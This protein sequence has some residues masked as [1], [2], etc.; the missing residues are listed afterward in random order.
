MCIRDSP[1]VALAVGLRSAGHQPVLVAEQH[2]ADLAG[3]H[4]IEFHALAGDIDE[5]MRP[6]GAIALTVEA[7]RLTAASMRGFRRADRAWLET[8]TAAATGSDVVVGMPVAGY[9]AVSYTHL[10]VYKRQPHEWS[11]S[12]RCPTPS[13]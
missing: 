4:Q 6:G 5:L 11:T 13:P 9:H 7:G 1:L 3:S 12:T 2:A 10:D 8:I